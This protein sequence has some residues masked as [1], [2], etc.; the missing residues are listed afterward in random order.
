M[1]DTIITFCLSFSLRIN[2]GITILSFDR[3]KLLTIRLP[4]VS[5]T[6]HIDFKE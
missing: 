5:F 2:P 6:I 1:F 4:F 3:F